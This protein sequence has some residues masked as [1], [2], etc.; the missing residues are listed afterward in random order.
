MVDFKDDV[1]MYRCLVDFYSDL[2][3]A[4][5]EELQAPAAT[6]EHSLGLEYLISK[7]LHERT[8][9]LYLGSSGRDMDPLEGMF[10]YGPA[11]NY[12]ATYASLYP[13]HFLASTMPKRV[14]ERLMQAL[15]LSSARWA[16]QESPKHDLH[17]IASLPRATLLPRAE[18]VAAWKVT[19]LSLLP[20]KATN[21]DALN[22]LA[23]VFH[24]PPKETITFPA[25]SAVTDGPDPQ[26]EL[27]AAAARALYLNYVADNPRFW[28]DI[29]SHAD[30]VAL[31]DHAL[32]ALNCLAAVIT[33]NWSTKPSLALPSSSI[34]TPESGH[35]AIL[36]PP[37]L[38]YTLPYL[39]KPPQTFANLV[40]GR[41]DAESAAY[42]IAAAKFDALKAFHGRLAVEVERDPGQG[43]EDILATIGKRLAEGPLSR[44]G[45]VGGQVGTLEL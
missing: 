38:E 16:H 32:A 8:A 29:A 7:A 41:G 20:S 45:E 2:L 9:S 33:A 27:E 39:L 30:T 17:L 5:R 15:E 34:P 1:L 6:A 31:K 36:S 10:L 23:T 19:P 18:G 12:I 44:E 42:K 43:Y 21:P 35:L 28:Q 14:N 22:T 26:Q 24:G 13:N 40:G 11:A 4:T 3:D 37:A 25:T